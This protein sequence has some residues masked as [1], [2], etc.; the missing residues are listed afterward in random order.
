VEEVGSCCCIAVRDGG[1]VW[2]GGLGAPS[3]CIVWRCRSPRVPVRGVQAG[4]A[5]SC[6]CG[7]VRDGVVGMVST[8]SR[9]KAWDVEDVQNVGRCGQDLSPSLGDDCL[10]LPCFGLA[11]LQIKVVRVKQK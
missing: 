10:S 5:G 9:C 1:G 11:L 6:C 3:R 2:L 8:P 7:V 4:E